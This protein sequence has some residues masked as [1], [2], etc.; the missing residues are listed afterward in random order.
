MSENEDNQKLAELQQVHAQLTESL[1]RCRK[2]LFECREQLVANSNDQ[3]K[4]G[5]DEEAVG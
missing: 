1:Q 2:M 4:S 3:P 5:D